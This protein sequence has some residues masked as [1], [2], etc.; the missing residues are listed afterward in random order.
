MLPGTPPNTFLGRCLKSLHVHGIF[1]LHQKI[2]GTIPHSCDCAVRC[3]LTGGALRATCPRLADGLRHGTLERG[4]ILFHPRERLQSFPLTLTGPADN[5]G[6]LSLRIAQREPD[7]RCEAAPPRSRRKKTR[8]S[9]VR[10]N[11]VRVIHGQENPSSP[12]LSH[13]SPSPLAEEGRGEGRKGP[14][15]ILDPTTPASC[16]G[17]REAR[18]FASLRMT[19]EVLRMTKAGE[20]DRGKENG[21]GGR[22]V[23]RTRHEH[24]RHHPWI[25]A[26]R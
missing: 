4:G 24:A 14:L 11:D 9:H 1:P 7:A 2:N 13:P 19:E 8:D 6:G 23:R 5:Y 12:S 21:G 15:S 10:G 17:N 22:N 25:S 3:T 20:N 26:P 18:F 16:P